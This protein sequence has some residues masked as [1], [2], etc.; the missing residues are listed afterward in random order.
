MTNSHLQ[1]AHEVALLCRPDTQSSEL[2]VFQWLTQSFGVPKNQAEDFT[3]T[4]PPPCS[5]S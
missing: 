1:A 4:L 2:E 5:K 3:V